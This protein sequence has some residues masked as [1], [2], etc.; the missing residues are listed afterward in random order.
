VC[1]RNYIDAWISSFLVSIFLGYFHFLVR[2]D[3]QICFLTVRAARWNINHLILKKEH[4][5]NFNPVTISVRCFISCLCS[6]AKY[7]GTSKN[8]VTSIT[9][10]QLLIVF[11]AKTIYKQHSNNHHSNSIDNFSYIPQLYNNKDLS[12]TTGCTITKTCGV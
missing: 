9:T 12:K 4:L 5:A 1:T 8:G 3:L 2:G 10:I 7:Y 11:R 6:Q